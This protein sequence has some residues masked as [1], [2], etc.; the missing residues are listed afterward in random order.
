MSKTLA[1]GVPVVAPDVGVA[2][3]AG[4]VVVP[5]ESLADA[6]IDILKSDKKGELK[7]TLLSEQAWANAW[8]ASLE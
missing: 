1:A 3:E 4:A 8:R 2:R 6:V 7:L 5:R